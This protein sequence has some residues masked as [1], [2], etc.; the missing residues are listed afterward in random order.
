MKRQYPKVIINTHRITENIRIAV[1]KCASV[2]IDIMGITKVSSGLAE[3]NAA[4]I[5]GGVHYLGSSRLE[6]LQ[7]AREQN[8]KVPLV[9][10]RIP[11]QYEISEVVRICDMSLQ[12]ELSVLRM[13]NN[14]A[15]RQ[16]KIHKVILMADLGD[17]REGFWDKEEFV[18]AAEIIERKMVGL[19][20]CGIGSNLGCYGAIAPTLD[21]MQE[22][23]NLADSVAQMIGRKLEMVSIGGSP[24]LMRVWLHDM[25]KGI[26]NIR[27]GGIPFMPRR[28]A[29]AYGE[30]F[31]FGMEKKTVKIQA[32]IVSLRENTAFLAFGEADYGNYEELLPLDQNMKVTG[33]TDDL[34]FVDVSRA[35]RKY[36]LGD[37]IEFDGTYTTLV[38][39]AKS[40]S[41]TIEYE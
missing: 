1:D 20:L 4:Y 3:P 29:E 11:M 14:F 8:V 9:M 6:Q 34:T 10:I 35:D 37:I 17:L 25:P 39:L 41:V 12:S 5:R 33:A 30:F 38:Y 40:P 18:R 27:V 19:H 24:A 16:G 2:G 21:K 23:S 13:A 15:L 31:G 36:K 28:N 32:E 7:S 22:L 26:T